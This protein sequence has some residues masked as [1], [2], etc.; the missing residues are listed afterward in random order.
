MAKK[1]KKEPVS[2]IIDASRE[3]EEVFQDCEVDN[4][5]SKDGQAELIAAVSSLI[6]KDENLGVT[7]ALMKEGVDLEARDPAGRTLLS[8]AA[9]GKRCDL[10]KIFVEHKA[11]LEAKDKGGLTALIWAARAG[12]VDEV[13]FLVEAGADVE[14]ADE[15]G[16]TAMKLAALCNHVDVVRVLVDNGADPKP[17]LEFVKKFKQSADAVRFLLT[18]VLNLG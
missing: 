16:M 15:D 1:K 11:N 5:R 10:L 13:R 2:N 8:L 9:I 6:E 18:V 3:E 14:A 4:V 17:A 7:Q 12:A